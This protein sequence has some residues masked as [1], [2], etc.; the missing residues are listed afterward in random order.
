MKNTK[1]IEMGHVNGLL[2]VHLGTYHDHRG[3]NFEGYN[4]ELY[5]RL[6]PFFK[7]VKFYHDS[8]SCSKR[9]VLR[10]FHGDTA[11]NKL[12]Q[13]LCGEIQLVVMDMREGSPT[14]R[15]TA[16][17]LLTSAQPCQIMVPAGCVNAHLCRSAECLFA[18]KLSVGYVPQHQQISVKYTDYPHWLIKNPILSERD[19]LL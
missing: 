19:S 5:G 1:I 12:I 15:K 18:Y 7:T 11:N 14:K 9:D 8:F 10:G 3:M 13:V 16:E 2:K 17:F 6:H 4:E